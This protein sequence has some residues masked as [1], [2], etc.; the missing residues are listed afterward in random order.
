M[1]RDRYEAVIVGAGPNG[2]AAAI[3][4]ARA[5]RSVLV[6]EANDT[7]GGG[8]RSAQLTLPGLTHDVCSAV[9][10]MAAA[11]SAFADWPLREHGLEW[12]EPPLAVAHPLDDGDVVTVECDLAATVNGLGEDGSAY[13]TL[14]GPVTRDWRTISDALFGPLRPSRLAR[15]PLVLGRFGLRALQPAT[16]G[17][18]RFRTVRGRALIAGVAAHSQLPLGQAATSAVPMAL[19]GAAHRVGWP[20][21]RGGSQAIADAL[22]GYLRSLDGELI[23]G[24]R[25]A[26]L[27]E[28]P[29]HR[30][31]L[32]DLTPRQVLTVS[33]ERLRGAYARALRRY[34]YGAG[35]FKVDLA[36]DGP[37]PWAN[38]DVLRAGTVHLGG[39]LEEIVAS[40]RAVSRGQVSQRPYVLLA[41]PSLFDPARASD[42]RHVAWAY[43]HVPNGSEVDM[44]EPILDQIE[45]FAPGA[46]RRIIGQSS[47]G[48]AALEARNA[49]VVGGDINGGSGDLLQIYT[50]PAWRLDP[51]STPDPQIFICSASTPPGGGTHGLCG[52]HAAR[53]ALRGVLR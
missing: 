51:Y 39:T 21:A 19:L 32:L 36:L 17:A 25:I 30:A 15:H 49:N 9:H 3:T 50:R 7:V 10:P 8:T 23:T 20:I 44:T 26:S 18:R 34:R 12:I 38:P 43:C 22:V 37:L 2:L 35:V 42:G 27:D 52:F 24:W 6:V 31:V 14:I 33:G 11:S 4:L 28:L 48:P 16:M 29:P 5:G 47:M 53:S 46:R 1:K 40:E 45:R 41:Q 13:R